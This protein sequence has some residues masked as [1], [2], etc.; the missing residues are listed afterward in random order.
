MHPPVAPRIPHA[1]TLHGETIVDD[2]FWLRD[3]GDPRVKA[4]LAAENA[5]TEAAL[6]GTGPLQERL[7]EEMLA[8]IKET[9]LSVPYRKGRYWYYARTEE[10]KQYP[11][12][13]RKLGALS[14]TEE[15]VLDLNVLARDHA[16]FAVSAFVVSD[17]GSLLAY[18]VDTTGFREYTLHVRDLRREEN[19]PESIERV[20]SVAWAA[21]GKTLFYVTDDDAKRAYRLWRHRLGEAGAVLIHEEMDERFS[22]TIRRSRSLGYLFLDADSHTAS[23][24]RFLA[25]NEP[26]GAFRIFLPRAPELEYEVDHGGDSFWIR[27][28]DRGRNYRLARCPVGA[29]AKEA[30][31]EVLPHRDAVNLAG[32]EVFA[33]HLVA[34]EREDGLER[35]VVHA[36]DAGEAHAIAFPEPA[37][38]T[39]PDIN[40]E[41]KTSTFRFRYQSMVT[42][43][44]IY[45]YDMATRAKTLMKRVEV[46]GGYDPSLYTVERAHAIAPDGTLVPV[47]F[48]YRKDTPRNGTAPMH[49]VGYGA[50]GYPLPVM[51]S[52]NR[53]SLLDRGAVCALAHVR[54][55]GELGKPW[56]DAGRMEH[57]P[58][59]FTDFIA[60][61]DFFVREAYAS[62]ERL[63]IEGGSAG[64]LLVGAVMNLRP[65]LAGGAILKVPFVDVI[66]TMLDT[67]L[68]L[69]VA[70]FEEWG[71]PTDPAQFALL[72]SYCPYSNLDRRP[73]PA[74]L[75]RTSIN[76]SQVMYWEPAK[77]V[78]RLRERNDGASQVLLKVNF[79]AG[80][81]GSSG[82]YDALKEIAFDVAW[83]LGVWGEGDTPVS[84]A[85]ATAIDAELGAHARDQAGRT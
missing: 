8:R 25:A 4:H 58:N 47:S 33:G 3:K 40:A 43:P 54:G 16:F 79:A 83:M 38:S 80:H 68:P 52:S 12:L 2:Y 42:P 45:D 14:S 59:S 67:S 72:R 36:L 41:F 64:G 37:Y 27:I 46:L 32:I 81:G 28:N 50:Y 77:Y 76:D 30:W 56:H 11:I 35:F 55:G 71:N 61:A 74:M 49:L 34:Y 78:A 31:T 20:S 48:A 60:V 85:S 7:Y 24:V 21:D 39:F 15:I 44:S 75:V 70:E 1:I 84:P 19:G 53:L 10:G 73:Y 26:D 17:D 62:R 9:D 82:R 13:A 6:H 22:L 18:S 63:I 57:K 23:E 69:T 65:D 51:F 66:N 29:T 5:C